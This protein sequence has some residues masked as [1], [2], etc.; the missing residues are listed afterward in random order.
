MI[1]EIA[2][3]KI[4]SEKRLQLLFTLHQQMCFFWFPN[5]NLPIVICSF[6]FN[7][8]LNFDGVYQSLRIVKNLV[9]TGSCHSCAASDGIISTF[10]EFTS[11]MI[12]INLSDAYCPAVK[13]FFFELKRYLNG[14][15][16]VFDSLFTINIS[17]S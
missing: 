17:S 8:E 5:A 10:L 14:H 9:D 2:K 3:S 13:V 16:I 11:L 12:K 1:P 6:N 4:P 15:T 7:R